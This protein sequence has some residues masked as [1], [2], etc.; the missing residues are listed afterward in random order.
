MNQNKIVR[1]ILERDLV[2]ALKTDGFRGKFPDF[3]RSENGCLHLLSIEFDKN[4]GGFFLEFACHPPGDMKTSWGEVVLEQNLTVA[5]THFEG[6]ARLQ[7]Y[8][9]PN[10]LSEDWFRYEKLSEKEIEK[11]V[12]HVC[13]IIYQAN[14]WLREKLVGQNIS[15]TNT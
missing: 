5:H 1:R 8:G 15:A 9:Q 7:L 13:S 11:L 10:S 3:Q 6:R 2:P 14:D 4:G 12:Q